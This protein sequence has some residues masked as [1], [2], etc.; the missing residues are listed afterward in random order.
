MKSILL[1]YGLVLAAIGAC[2]MA[3]AK[4]ENG[5]KK[6]KGSKGLSRE[7]VLEKYDTDGDGQLSDAEL[8]ALK[9]D[10]S[11]DRE[12]RATGGR[13]G[14]MRGERGRGGPE[15]RERPSREEMIK[16]F[17]TDG[18]GVLSEAERAEARKQMPKDGR[19]GR[20]NRQMLEKYDTDGD[21]QLSEE[22]RAAARADFE[23]RRAER[24]PRGV[25][26]E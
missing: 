10:V 12:K 25:D 21:G 18:D 9:A 23:K 7:A 15:G 5:Q 3:D 24:G 11:A 22:E 19:R 6:D 26:E 8:D 20:R 14:E 4:P 2:S 13:G 16:K 17:D 1:K